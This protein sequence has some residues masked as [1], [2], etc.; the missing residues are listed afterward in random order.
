MSAHVRLL[1]SIAL[2]FAVLLWGSSF[3]AM[4]VA[5]TA[6]DPLLVIFGRMAVATLFFSLLARRFLRAKYQKGDWIPMV[7]MALCEPG[8]YF[9]FEAY[10]LTLTTAAQGG[11]VTATLP[12]LVTAAAFVWLQERPS[13]RIWLGFILAMGGV[14]WLS[15]AG[16]IQEAAPNPI[17]GNFMVFMAMVCATGYTLLLKKLSVRYSPWLLTAVQAVVGTVFYLPG[18]LFV[19]WGATLANSTGML[20]WASV[21]YLGACVSIGAYGCYN[22]GMSRLPASQASAFINGIPVVSVILAWLLLGERL[23]GQQLVACVVVFAGVLLSQGTVGHKLEQS[24]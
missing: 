12:V 4:K 22:Y 21:F 17:L 14:V 11:M 7:L 9:L 10:G 20:P 6:L 13:L 3:I 5:V 15:L 18:L 8:L 2:C 1:P 19:D 16:E 23:N 24:G